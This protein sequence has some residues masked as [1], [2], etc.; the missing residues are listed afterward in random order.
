MEKT[1]PN[2]FHLIIANVTEQVFDGAVLS[3]TF[4]GTDGVLTILPHHESFV[5]TLKKGTIRA[6][7]TIDGD[8]EFP[9]ESGVL[10]FSQNRATV[11]L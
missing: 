7:T 8:K 1:Y 10:E 6:R 9:I 2:T 11:L 5:T 4:P 3:A